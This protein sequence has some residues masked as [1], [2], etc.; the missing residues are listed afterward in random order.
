[1]GN[2]EVFRWNF[3]SSTNS[4]IERSV[5][6]DE[7]LFGAGIVKMKISS[8]SMIIEHNFVSQGFVS[9]ER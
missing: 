8:V 9:L 5:G 3:S 7:L 2:F 4:E 1:M 6:I